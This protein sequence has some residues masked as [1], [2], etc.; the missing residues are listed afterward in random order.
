MKMEMKK[1]QALIEELSEDRKLFAEALEAMVD[2][3]DEE[4]V[5]AKKK[6]AIQEPVKEVKKINGSQGFGTESIADSIDLRYSLDNAKDSRIA[7]N[8]RIEKEKNKIKSIK[9]QDDESIWKQDQMNG[10]EENMQN[11]SKGLCS[12]GLANYYLSII[13]SKFGGRMEHKRN[14]S[15]IVQLH[16]HGFLLLNQA[17]D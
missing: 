3:E 1:K 13:I 2:E 8:K 14:R 17:N 7:K 15:E 11:I 12:K 6:E 9:R 4:T 10:K 16:W 5:Q